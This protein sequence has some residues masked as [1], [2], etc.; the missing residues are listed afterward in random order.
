MPVS[1]LIPLAIAL[2]EGVTKIVL[3]IQNDTSTTQQEKDAAIARI[4]IAL[5][6]TD[7]KVQEVQV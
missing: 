5:A 7:R 4:R 6:D 1:E 2:A 3:A